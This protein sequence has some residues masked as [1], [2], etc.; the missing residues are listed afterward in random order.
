[1]VFNKLSTDSGVERSSWNRQALQNFV[2]T[3]GFGAGNGSLRASSFPIAVLASFGIVGTSLFGLFFIG[4]F[5]GRTKSS[6]CDPLDEANQMAA[7]SLCVAWLIAATVSGAL[8]DL[9][10]PFFAF[11][12]L[13]CSDLSPV[14]SINFDPEKRHGYRAI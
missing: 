2:D 6:K 13:A 10:L 12:A 4:L 5:F 7:G 3:Y 14:N 11:A 1:M 8:T 9:G